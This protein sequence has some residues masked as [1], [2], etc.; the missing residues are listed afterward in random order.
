[1]RRLL[2]LL[3]FLIACRQKTVRLVAAHDS[4]AGA[5]PLSADQ[6]VTGKL[7]TGENTIYFRFRVAEQAM[8]RAELSAVRGAD[9]RLE[10]LS[11]RGDVLHLAD[12]HG[13]SIAE[14]MHPVLLVPGDY[15]LRLSATAELA[16]DF[17]LFYR[18]FKAPADVEREPNNA[19]ETATAVAATHA[20][21]FYGAEFF[22]D[23]KD[24]SREQDCFRFTATVEGKSR[25]GFT[26]TGVDGYTASLRVLDKGGDVLA[27]G[28]TEKPGQLLSVGPVAVPVDRLLTVCVRATRRQPNASRDYYDLDMRLTEAQVK[29]ESEPNNTVQT[30]GEITAASM[31]GSISAVND[32]DYFYWQN[33]REYPVILR[34]EVVSLT[35]QLLKLEAGVTPALRSFEGSAEKSA[36]ADNLRVDAGDRVAFIIGCG[37][38]CNRKTFKPV[39]YLLRLDESQATDENEFEP[40]DS[41]DRA[42][43]L[44]DLTQKWGF[45]NPPGDID[46]YRLTLSQNGVRDVIVESRLNCRL[47]L[48]HL[49]D[50]KSLAISAGK[51]KVIYNAEFARDDLLRLQ[52]AGDTLSADRSYRLSVNEP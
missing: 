39:N 30:A 10:I 17:T 16:E 49:R 11:S 45:I 15:L 33:R 2:F 31:E 46:Y 37:K 41:P 1:M 9:T 6:H 51:G 43:T 29:S 36:V 13:S 5:F 3:F 7:H 20:S 42:E 25:A 21:G 19:P 27:A 44:V 12:D 32:V 40:N 4:A 48:E 8:F 34:A 26:L 38:R 22:F 28:E 35:P 18:L 52:C 50:G 14:E 24:K 23:G 47:R